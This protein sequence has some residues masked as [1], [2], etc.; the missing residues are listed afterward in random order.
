M[1]SGLGSERV[2]LDGLRLG[3]VNAETWQ[4]LTELHAS[5]A[6]RHRVSVFHQRETRSPLFR[7]RIAR[8]RLRRDLESY[9]SAHDA[10]FFEWASELLAQATRLPKR[11]A[12]I[13][14]LH[15]YELYA[16][17]RRIE[18]DAVD[19]IILVSEAKRREFV[20]L[21]PQQAHKTHVVPVG[22]SLRRFQ[23]AQRRHSN[24][25]GTLCNLSPRKRVYELVLAFSDLLHRLPSV[26]LFIGGGPDPGHMDYYEA[27]GHLV[28]RLG[29]ES[30][31]TFDGAIAEP[32]AWY[33]KI[34]VF[35]SNSYS[36]GL[37]VAPM[38]A[39]AS[40]CYTLAHEWAGADELLPRDNR[41]VTHAE[42]LDKLERYYRVS[43]AERGKEQRR[44]RALAAERF[45]VEKATTVIDRIIRQC[46]RPDGC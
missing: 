27:L 10:V 39:M 1:A 12:I 29:L 31:V 22:V 36:E 3:F 23:F 8:H 11:C 28:K 20:R 19:A 5:L 21:F 34:D 38:E 40:G 7:E 30:V 42:L 14:R 2:G 41:Y 16:W 15:R 9:L 13:T 46:V 35:V 44:M 18:W 6:A 33:P 4:F 32:W 25:I 43:D 37:Q 45:D 17:A 26:R 24:A